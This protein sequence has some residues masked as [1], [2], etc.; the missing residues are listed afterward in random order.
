M[1]SFGIPPSQPQQQQ[2]NPQQ[3]FGNMTGNASLP[4]PPQQMQLQFPPTTMSSAL[5]PSVSPMPGSGLPPTSGFDAPPTS[6]GTQM[7]VAN[8]MMQSQTP[9][10]Q[11]PYSASP[12]A[13]QNFSP[14]VARPTLQP[15]IF[16]FLYF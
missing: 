16:M 15:G 10:Q 8:A 11:M 7:S 1:P 2:Q 9:P 6:F 4:Q 14:A 12:A 5:P 13:L 3:P